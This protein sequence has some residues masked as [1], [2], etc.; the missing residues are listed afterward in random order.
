MPFQSS[1][2]I[3]MGAGV[4]GELYTDA[5]F[6][7]ETFTIVSASAAYNII[8]TACCTVSSQGVCEAGSGGA[9][10]FAGFLVSPKT[11][12]LY[13]VGN[14]PLTPTLTVP[15]NNIVTCLTMG[16]IFVTLPAAAAIGDLVVY[17][18]TTG[19]IETIAPGAQ[20]PAGKTF[21]NAIVDYFT[22]TQAGLAV[23]SV[24]P[25]YVIP[26]P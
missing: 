26:Q 15:N 1:V 18:N 23:V 2:F 24:D 5:P 22:V 14:S 12:A 16:T 17:D 13:G 21:A 7:A 8:G 20:L 25:T 10:G 3:N 4:P 9:G 6:K 19:A 11:Q